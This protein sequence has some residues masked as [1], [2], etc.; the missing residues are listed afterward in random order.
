[1]NWLGIDVGGANLKISDGAGFALSRAFALWKQPQELPAVMRRLVADAPACGGLAVTMT[2]ELA[3]CFATKAEG[4]RFILYAV[5]SAAA[6]RKICVYLTDGRFVPP[7]L[8]RASL[9]S[10]A[11]SN[12]HALA[13]FSGRYAPAGSA[14]LIDLGSTTCDIIPLVDGRPRASGDT[15]TSRLLAGELVYTGIERS[16]V[17]AITDRVPYRGQL[18]PV[19]QEL[20]ATARDVYLVLEELAEQPQ[21]TDTADGRPATRAAAL[22]RL[23][24]GSC[25][26]GEEFNEQDGLSL[27]GAV[28]EA[29]AARLIV[30]VQQV[31]Q[32]L[33]TPPATVILA[34]HGDFL[35][36]RV[37]G[38]CGISVPIVSLAEKL[39]PELSRCATAYAL[40][41]LA[42]EAS[43]ACSR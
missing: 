42:R 21:N 38:E 15:D 1:M 32:R 34:G 19:A 36:R 22:A 23:G 41:V 13:R 33:P 11:A 28:A 14:L 20:F 35:V 7:R 9:L 39:G 16:P 37:L 18:C 25:A 24:R 27:A 10:A 43:N 12:W 5:C 40:A 31:R 26:D 17:C 8:A 4:V 2:G 30:A 6:L 29:Q 3:D